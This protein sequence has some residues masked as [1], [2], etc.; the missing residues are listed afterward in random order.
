MYNIFWTS[1]KKNEVLS[2]IDTYVKKYPY[3]E[4]IYQSDQAQIDGLDL[5]CTISDILQPVLSLDGKSE[6]CPWDN[7]HG[8]HSIF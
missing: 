1:D 5:L 6:P 7:T 3:G 4:S 2:L 8:D